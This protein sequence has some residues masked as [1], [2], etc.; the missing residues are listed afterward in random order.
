MTAGEPFVGPREDEGAGDTGL[1]GGVHLPRQDAPL[2]LLALAKRIYAEFG[3]HERLVERDIVQPRDV[4]SESRLVVQ[5]NVEAN[6][7]GEIDRQ[8]F[9]GWIIGVTDERI[10]M[11]GFGADD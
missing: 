5:I 1:E 3:Q 10:W 9:G 4:S 6:E 11:F 2:F 7:I 8:I